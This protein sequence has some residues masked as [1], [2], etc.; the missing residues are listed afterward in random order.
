MF[1]AKFDSFSQLVE[2]LL[3]FLNRYQI[4]F[5]G[6]CLDQTLSFCLG[7]KFALRTIE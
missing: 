3:L 6:D 5:V 2:C 1:N 7:I 4:E